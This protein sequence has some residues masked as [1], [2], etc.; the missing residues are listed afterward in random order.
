[1]IDKI[2][3]NEKKETALNVLILHSKTH[4]FEIDV[5]GYK[6]EFIVK[7]PSLIEQIKIGTLLSKLTEGIDAKQLDI[8]TN[9]ISFMVATLM[10]VIVKSPEWFNLDNLYDYTVLDEIYTKYADW[11]NSFRSRNKQNTD[12]K[13]SS[14]SMHEEDMESL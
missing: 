3:E 13:Y 14:A 1:M 5:D 7:Y 6:G 8:I 11:A 12:E 2:N 10:V 4:T 9:N